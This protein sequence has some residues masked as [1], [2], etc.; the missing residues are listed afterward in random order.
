MGFEPPVLD[1]QHGLPEQDRERRAY[2]RREEDQ[3]N[4]AP[5]VVSALLALCG[6]LAALFVF[7]VL[8]DAIDP[9]DAVVATVIAVIMGLV[10]FGAFW[11]R[12]RTQAGRTQWRDRER[13][14]F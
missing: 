13:R 6:A 14:G 8:M 4:L 9:G 12:L 10:W 3:R 5:V 2:M 11:Y 1:Q 7:F